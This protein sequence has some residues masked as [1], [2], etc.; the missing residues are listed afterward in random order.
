MLLLLFFFVLKYWRDGKVL[1]QHL[2]G[3]A[4][5]CNQAAVKLETV[6][7]IAG[8]DCDHDAW[9]CVNVKGEN[10]QQYIQERQWTSQGILHTTH[11]ES[12]YCHL[13]LF[14]YHMVAVHHR[15][16]RCSGHDGHTWSMDSQDVAG[17]RHGHW[18]VLKN[19]NTRT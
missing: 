17:N 18:A 5:I 6:H 16:P 14:L 11:A 8:P 7:P 3:C 9:P 19:A 2:L 12:D 10:V 1:L 4:W 15:P 13:I